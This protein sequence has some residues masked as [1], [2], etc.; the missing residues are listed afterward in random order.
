MAK[1]T[2]LGSIDLAALE[3]LRAEARRE[4]FRF[5]ERF[6]DEWRS[7]VN[8]FSQAGEALFA[9]FEDGQI[10]GICGLNRDPYV[11]GRR[12]GRV[13]RLYVVPT[14]RGKSIGQQLLA[15]VTE[16]AL[17][18]FDVLRVRSETAGDFFT[19]HGF[20]VVEFQSDATH[21]LELKKG[22]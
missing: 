2:R 11:A 20:S 13:R 16:H 6:C 9:A 15:A 4:G 12:I 1:V 14:R 18:H 19:R 3:G 17:T 7:G 10:V 8:R 21:V 22:A 5:V